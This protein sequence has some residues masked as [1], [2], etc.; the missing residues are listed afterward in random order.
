[1]LSNLEIIGWEIF[2]GLPNCSLVFHCLLD[3]I[4]PVT[5]AF[6]QSAHDKCVINKD[7][8][9]T[10]NFATIIVFEIGSKLI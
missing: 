6:K 3:D 4:L 5:L 9:V 2:R 10:L 1:M 7:S 8:N